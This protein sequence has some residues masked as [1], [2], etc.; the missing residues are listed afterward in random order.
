MHAVLFNAILAVVVRCEGRESAAQRPTIRR[1]P[2]RGSIHFGVVLLAMLT[3]VTLDGCSV[4]GPASRSYTENNASM[5]PTLAIAQKIKMTIV[6]AGRYSPARGDI[7]VILM[8]PAWTLNGEKARDLKRV[9]GLPGDRLEC[10]PG[11]TGV[12]VNGVKQSEN[13]IANNPSHACTRPFDLTIPP[14]RVWVM[15]D[16]RADSMDS[17]LVY[18]AGSADAITNATV[19]LSSIEAYKR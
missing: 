8:P 15:G 4:T 6:R 5:A 16:N 12:T 14:D 13:Y 11:D 3:S 17:G 7:V 18:N 9:I 10:T 1:G 19:P 2:G